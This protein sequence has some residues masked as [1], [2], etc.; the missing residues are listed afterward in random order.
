MEGLL[1]RV[2][3]RQGVK[4]PENFLSERYD[5]EV[6]AV[7]QWVARGI[8]LRHRADF[9]ALAG[10]SLEELEAA[11]RRPARKG[12]RRDVQ[13][14]G[15]QREGVVEQNGVCAGFPPCPDQGA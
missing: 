6:Y 7:R 13:A 5:I 11:H 2:A 12:G 1:V 3:E 10:M 15:H 9:A 4:R 14:A 8:P